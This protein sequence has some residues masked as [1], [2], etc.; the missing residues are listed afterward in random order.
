[1]FQC[2]ILTQ[3]AFCGFNILFLS[4]ISYQTVKEP[5]DLGTILSRLN[6]FHYKNA[7]ECIADFRLLASNCRTFNPPNDVFFI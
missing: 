3:F 4:F 6:K 5:M 7:S 2:Q 1:M